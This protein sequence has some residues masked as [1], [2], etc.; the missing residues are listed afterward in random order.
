MLFLKLLGFMISLLLLILKKLLRK[1]VGMFADGTFDELYMY[2]SHYVSAITQEVTEKK[3]LP[4]TDITTSN[5][6]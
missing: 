2:Y 3:L 1:A 6:S 4:L 5:E